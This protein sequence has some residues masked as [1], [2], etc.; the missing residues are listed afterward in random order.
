MILH[1]IFI[2]SMAVNHN[3]HRMWGK[4]RWV[5][6]RLVYA[7]TRG[8]PSCASSSSWLDS[9]TRDVMGVDK[10]EILKDTIVPAISRSESSQSLLIEITDVLETLPK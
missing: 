8:I 1:T 6:N 4:I 5:A 2:V 9:K 3:Q 10:L 7:S